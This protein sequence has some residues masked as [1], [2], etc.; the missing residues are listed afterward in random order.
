MKRTKSPSPPP[1]EKAGELTDAQWL[2]LLEKDY[3][4]LAEEVKL[5]YKTVKLEPLKC[6]N[7]ECTEFTQINVDHLDGPGSTVCEYDDVCTNCG[8]L[9]GHW[10][11]GNYTI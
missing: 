5:G 9:N 11:Y 6:V 1:S 3:P 10:A 4:P 8:Y 2:A 7:C